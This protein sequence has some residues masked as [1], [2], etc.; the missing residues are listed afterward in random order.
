MNID[1]I[2]AIENVFSIC[3][4]VSKSSLF[5][6]IEYSLKDIVKCDLIYFIKIISK[7]NSDERIMNFINEY[8]DGEKYKILN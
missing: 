3:D 8:F 7:E 6:D 4:T 1:I 2:N 5:N